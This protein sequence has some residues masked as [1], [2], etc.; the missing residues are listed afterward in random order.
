MFSLPCEGVDLFGKLAKEDVLGG[1][2]EHQH[3]VHVSWPQLHQVAYVSDICQLRYLHKILLG[4]PTKINSKN[5]EL[6][7]MMIKAALHKVLIWQL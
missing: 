1:V 7:N 4:R 5:K 2:S 3:Y 6:K